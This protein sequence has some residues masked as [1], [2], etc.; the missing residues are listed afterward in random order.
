META[1]TT[2]LP[3]TN[4]AW[5]FWGTI[6]RCEQGADPAAAWTLASAE[7]AAATQCSASAV[8]DFLDSRHGRHFADEVAGHLFHGACLGDAIADAV[9]TWMGWTIGRRMQRETGIPHELRY[10]TGLVLHA[11]IE[12][13][14]A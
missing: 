3:T 5:G 7:I 14:D 1:M 6:E 11:E 10:L 12:A 13:E 4:T 8:R 2:V 9:K